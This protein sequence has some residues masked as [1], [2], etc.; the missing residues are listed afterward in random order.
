MGGRVRAG[1]VQPN[2]LYGNRPRGHR[3]APRKVDVRGWPAESCS[4]LWRSRDNYTT[5]RAWG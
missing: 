5:R 3:Y 1:N 2:P 4:L